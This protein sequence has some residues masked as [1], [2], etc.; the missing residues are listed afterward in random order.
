[1]TIY[2]D[3]QII[4]IVSNNTDITGVLTFILI[5]GY[6]KEPQ[7][8]PC[9][10]LEQNSRYSKMIV[11]FGPDFKEQHKNG[12]YYYTIANVTTE[13]ESGYAKII[14]EP[15]GSINTLSYNAGPIVENREATV[16]YR[17]NY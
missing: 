11:D 4:P 15:G 16:Y 9:T 6:S 7:N 1:M 5:S 14:T 13:F 17:P 8:F 3:D 2:V 12:V 10:L